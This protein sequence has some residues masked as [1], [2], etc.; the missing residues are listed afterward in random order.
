MLPILIVTIIAVAIPVL[1]GTILRLVFRKMPRNLPALLA[2]TLLFFLWE[3]IPPGSL[4]TL[5]SIAMS[6]SPAGHAVRPTLI[7]FTFLIYPIVGVAIPF[8]F[9]W[10]GAA[11]VDRVRNPNQL[12]SDTTQKLAEQKLT[13]R[14][15]RLVGGLTLV[16]I[17]ALVVYLGGLLLECEFPH[18]L[19]IWEVAYA[20]T[21]DGKPVSAAVASVFPPS[22]YGTRWTTDS[23]CDNTFKS[24]FPRVVFVRLDVWPGGQAGDYRSTKWYF[25]G[26]AYDRA[27]NEIIP[28]TDKTAQLFPSLLPPTAKVI[29]TS[30]GWSDQHILDVEGWPK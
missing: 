15:A 27:G 12:P 3:K 30:A 14:V 26:F 2:A 21:W 6:T 5:L 10:I 23:Y 29:P 24:N 11:L 8:L 7:G 22:N 9:A 18:W 4:Q 16:C 19:T 1:L 20:R 17:V 13:K 28:A 25:L